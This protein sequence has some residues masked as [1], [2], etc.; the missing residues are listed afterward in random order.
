MNILTY[1][2]MSANIRSV[3]RKLNEV[4]IRGIIERK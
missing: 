2:E 4:E 1:I 3:K